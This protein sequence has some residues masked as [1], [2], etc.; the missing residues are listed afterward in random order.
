VSCQKIRAPLPHNCPEHVLR[1]FHDHHERDLRE[2]EIE[3]H[4]QPHEQQQR[5]H[6][7]WLVELSFN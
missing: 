5:Q 3:R 6:D 1:A 7:G 4:H 2:I